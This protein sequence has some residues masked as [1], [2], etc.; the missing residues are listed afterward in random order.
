MAES[1][2]A[3]ALMVM[4]T[5]P[6]PP[7]VD[8]YVLIAP[9]VWGRSKMNFLM[10]ASL[11]LANQ[12]VPGLTLTGRGIVKVTASD[13]QQ[14]LVRLSTDPLTI[15]AT[16]VDA[17]KGLVDLMDDALAAAARFRRAGAVSVRRA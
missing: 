11:W 13:N 9:A 6:N 1:M 15:H 17:I 2:G 4:A 10:R 7:A 8:G 12:T 3:A 14:A 5:E 16:R